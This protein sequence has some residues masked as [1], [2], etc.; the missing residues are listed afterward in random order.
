MCAVTSCG[1]C[2]TNFEWSCGYAKRFGAVYVDYETLT[3]TPKSSAAWYPRAA[4][5]GELPATAD[6]G[7]GLS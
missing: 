6:Q 3:R 5:P 2:W 4:R 7:R 1:R